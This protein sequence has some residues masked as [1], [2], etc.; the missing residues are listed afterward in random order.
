MRCPHCA[1]SLTYRQRGN[2]R[3]SVCKREF[4]LEPKTQPMKLSDTGLRKLAEKMSANGALFYTPAQV[5]HYASRKH[6]AAQK[7]K[8]MPVG[9]LLIVV[10]VIGGLLTNVAPWPVVALLAAGALLIGWWGIRR[11]RQRPFY[12]QLPLT[13]GVFQQRVL[14]R[15]REVYGQLPA[16]LIDQA[17]LHQRRRQP[18]PGDLRAVLLCP[19]PAI[20]DCLQANDLP[21]RLGLGLL[22]LTDQPDADEQALLAALRARPSLPLLLLHDASPAGCT[23]AATIRVRLGLSERQRVIDL[24]L[25]PRQA[26]A[27][28]LM[29]LGA[30][31][32]PELLHL[33]RKRVAD[34]AAPPDAARAALQPDELAWLEQGCV[35]PVLALPPARLI[36]LVTKAVERV[37]P[38]TA[39]VDPEQAAQEQARAVG[40]MT[41]PT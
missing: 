34:P 9:C 17:D 2:Q 14:E 5:L 7:P 30:P 20:L 41:W 6:V 39:R 4:A 26:V 33:L 21:A 23:L 29:R 38:A 13:L 1:T 8:T 28:K 22:R 25:R 24:G 18:A 12:P 10:L 3:C 19:E 36:N 16:G 35:S 15:W 32:P 27:Q 37:A 40:F 31:P 11:Q